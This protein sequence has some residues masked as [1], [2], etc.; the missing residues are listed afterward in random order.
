M[1]KKIS[2]LFL[3]ILL[4]SCSSSNSIS[5]SIT[6][7]LETQFKNYLTALT[8]KKFELAISYMPDELFEYVPKKTVLK[9]LEETY[10][11]PIITGYYKDVKVFED[12]KIVKLN[13]I[14]YSK[15]VYEAIMSMRFSPL[16][17]E[18]EN[19]KKERISYQLSVLREEYGKDLKGY[20]EETN[21][22]DI[23]EKREVFALK[24]FQSN[25]WKY[26]VLDPRNQNMIKELFPDVDL[27][28]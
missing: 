23:Y 7:E 28:D 27:I 6:S 3:L 12:V 11:D 13:N 2:H 25:Q 18:T 4:L 22:I 5:K 17:E 26:L 9:A 1:F 8:T 20:N 24:K 15:F 19:E 21:S 10:G 16:N 14:V